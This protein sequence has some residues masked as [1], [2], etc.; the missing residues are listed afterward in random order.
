MNASDFRAHMASVPT[1]VVI[2]ASLDQGR[3][4]GMVVG[5]FTSVSLDPPLV[6]F[7]GDLGSTTMP[8]LIGTGRIAFSVLARD[9]YPTVTDAFRRRAD[10]RFDGVDWVPSPTGMPRVRP[11]V[12]HVEGPVVS[13]APAG[14]HQ[15]VR[16]SP[17]LIEAGGGDSPLV[18]WG[19]R[20]MGVGEARLSAPIWQLGRV[21]GRSGL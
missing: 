4:V 9:A 12:L 13:T 8:T 10:E 3:P 5:T 21:D 17:T 19:G 1:S 6:G 2:A 11:A 15:I 7:L 18:F 20:M 16:V 14:D